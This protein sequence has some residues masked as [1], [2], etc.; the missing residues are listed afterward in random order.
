MATNISPMNDPRVDA[1]LDRLHT[2][3]SSQEKSLIWKNVGQ[4][5][6]LLSGKG[7]HFK[8]ETASFYDDKYISIGKE[9]GKLLYLLALATN[10]KNIVEFG[11]SFGIS[12]IYLA[13]A[14]RDIG[15][16]A[17][18][19]GSE[20]VPS[21]LA[22][23]RENLTEAGLTDFVEIR[24]GDALMTLASG[25]GEEPI[26]LLLLDGFPALAFDVLKMLEPKL[27]AGALVLVDDVNLFKADLA[28]L[29]AY[30][31]DPINGYSST[32][33]AL[34]DGFLMSVRRRN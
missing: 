16:G 20:I 23:A 26:D 19:I 21:K 28:P 18:V 12:S 17:K 4:L 30:M 8:S 5:P 6:S 24:E 3:S 2:E 33:I 14:A 27:K 31:Q 32:T 34:D 7:I 10:A 11:S 29:V 9:Q 13:C 22:R 25:L 15:D 1:V